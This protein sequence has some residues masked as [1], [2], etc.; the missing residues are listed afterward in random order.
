MACRARSKLLTNGC[1]LGVFRDHLG[2]VEEGDERLVG[3]LDEEELQRVAIERDA[4]QRLQDAV[5]DGA[6]GNYSVD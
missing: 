4:L 3:G 2:L 1:E 5:E 6:S